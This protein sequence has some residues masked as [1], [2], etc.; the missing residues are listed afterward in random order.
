MSVLQCI[1]VHLSP[2]L[3]RSAAHSLD[4]GTKRLRIYGYPFEPSTTPAP[5][6]APASAVPVLHALPLTI[7]AFKPYGD[8]IQGFSL[9]SSN[10]KG[11]DV[12]VANQSSAAKFHRLAKIQETYP[13]EALVN[14]GLGIGLVR[15]GPELMVGSGTDVDI[16]VL[17]R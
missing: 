7:E 2:N 1:Q 13:P 17:E 11:V 9:A 16:T 15:A 5:A 3:Y 6:P 12:S 4:G 14:G 10:P 8:I